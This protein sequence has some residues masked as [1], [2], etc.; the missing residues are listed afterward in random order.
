MPELN[1]LFEEAAGQCS[2]LSDELD[3][4]V[5]GIDTMVGKAGEVW[6]TVSRGGEQV[7]RRLQQLTDRLEAAEAALERART[8][9]VG[10][11]D[12]L[13]T[14]AESVRTEVGELLGH[15]REG[16]EALE[17]LETRLSDTIGD[18]VQAVGT[19]YSDLA[20]RVQETQD[21]IATQVQEAGQALVQFRDAVDAAR[22]ELATKKD[23][24]SEA[25]DQLE[26]TAQEQTRAWVEGLQSVLADQT[27]AMIDMANRMLVK[28]ND[29][30]EVLKT[31]FETEAAAH[32]AASILPLQDSLEKLG[33]LATSRGGELT[34]RSAEALQRVRAALPA[35][36]EL[37]HAFEQS[38]RLG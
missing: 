30:M 36:E 26:T 31:K 4:T 29:T 8:G 10:E 35:L 7:R 2:A 13:A 27:T 18:Q 25:L 16:L 37:R 38:S 23:T 22:G 34:A 9:A 11:I 24:W 12:D 3:D 17:Q 6:E 15:V 19:D 33:E 32:V 1:E 5:A 28:H 14:R 21:T 20:Q